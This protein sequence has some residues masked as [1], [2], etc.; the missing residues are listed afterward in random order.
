VKLRVIWTGKTRNAHLAELSEDYLGRIRRLLP[1]DLVELKEPRTADDG[2]RMA[3][4]AARIL[5]RIAPE[6]Y[7]IALDERGRAGTSGELA[8]LVGERMGDGRGDLVFVIGGPAGLAQDLRGR[9][10]GL[11][12]LSKLTFSHDLA[13]AVLLEQIYRALTIVR[14]L[15]YPK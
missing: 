5:G 13:R 15:P 6:D 2:R 4:E 8:R 9:A 7:V 11:L 12:A 10:D 1:L 14:N 3:E